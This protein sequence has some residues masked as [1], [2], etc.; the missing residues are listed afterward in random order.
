MYYIYI[1]FFGISCNSKKK[2]KLKSI[3]DSK[4]SLKPKIFAL[5]LQFIS[6]LYL[7]KVI[8]FKTSINNYLFVGV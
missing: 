3:Q 6:L 1:K 7:P 4:M 8:W 5:L 2:K